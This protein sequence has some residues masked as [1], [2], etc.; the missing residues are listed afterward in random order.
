M[1]DV[2]FGASELLNQMTEAL[3]Q[4]LQL[5]SMLLFYFTIEIIS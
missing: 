4:L 2:H 1:G 3:P 5:A